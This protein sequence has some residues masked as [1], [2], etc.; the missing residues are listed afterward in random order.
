MLRALSL[1]ST[2][3]DK[4]DG[5]AGDD[6]TPLD[7]GGTFQHLLA[8]SPAGRQPGIPGQPENR[9]SKAEALAPFH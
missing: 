6:Q 9:S 7:G 8:L 2:A 3:K 5:E 1:T 4:L